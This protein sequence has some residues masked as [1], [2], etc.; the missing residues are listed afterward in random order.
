MAFTGLFGPPRVS[1]D[2]FSRWARETAGVDPVHH[3]H[4]LGACWPWLRSGR[5]KVLDVGPDPAPWLGAIER[6]AGGRHD[7][8]A[9]RHGANA[10]AA[11]S[12]PR[13]VRVLTA[14]F[15]VWSPLAN[16]DAPSTLSE[17]GFTLVT[18]LQLVDHLYHPET[19]FRSLFDAM[20]TRAVLVLTAS[21]VSRFANVLGLVRGEGLAGDL[22]A[23]IDRGRPARPLVREYNWRELNA[24]ALAAGFV[25][26][27]HGFYDDPAD[28]PAPSPFGAGLRDAAAPFLRERAQFAS[29]I[30]LVFR[31][32]GPLALKVRQAR[33]ALYPL[34]REGYARAGGVRRRLRAGR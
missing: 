5:Q 21:N 16:R 24:A 29:E 33:L 8:W 10:D 32:V 13:G 17:T 22:D 23:L 4:A 6:F 9:C 7:L 27:R 28:A 20:A 1:I 31:K 25:P 18:A 34:L 2:E 19:L 14:E 26:V 30:V 15:D 12:L 11:A 3:Y